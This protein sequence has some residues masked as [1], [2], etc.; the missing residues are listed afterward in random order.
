MKNKITYYLFNVWVVLFIGIVGVILTGSNNDIVFAIALSCLG[1]L[2]LVV[3]V[4]TIVGI[5]NVIKNIIN[6]S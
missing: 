2:S 6:K 1:Y 4:L 3:I 5:V